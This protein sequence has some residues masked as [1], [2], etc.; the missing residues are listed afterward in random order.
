MKIYCVP[1]A[2]EVEARL[3]SGREIYPHRPDLFSLPFWRCDI[4]GGYVGCHHKTADRTRPLGCIP[5]RE[6]MELRKQI[7]A[8][9]DPIWRSKRMK[10][11]KVYA[12]LGD[13]L[14]REYHTGEL[15]SV[16]EAQAVLRAARQLQVHP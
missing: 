15:R 14:G 13:A 11:G 3:A 4:C 12:K 7:H 1:C 6:L 9:I 8:I 16:E 10:R 2:R 5:G